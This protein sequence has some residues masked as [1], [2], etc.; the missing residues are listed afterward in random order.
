MVKQKFNWCKSKSKEIQFLFTQIDAFLFKHF[1]F[2]V[3]LQRFYR[4]NELLHEKEKE[5]SRHVVSAVSERPPYKQIFK[6]ALPQLFNVFFIFLVT[7]TLFPAV[8]AGKLALK[9][10]TA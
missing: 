10:K 7:L 1:R 3:H 6:Q 2:L 5:K 9:Y 4:Y 8:Q